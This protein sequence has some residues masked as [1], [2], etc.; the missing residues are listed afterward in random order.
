MLTCDEDTKF[1]L[2]MNVDMDEDEYSNLLSD[3]AMEQGLSD[4]GG[5]KY[6][7]FGE[8]YYCFRANMREARMHHDLIHG[9]MGRNEFDDYYHKKEGFTVELDGTTD[10]KRITFMWKEL[11]TRPTDIMFFAP[12]RDTLHPFLDLF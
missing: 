3:S 9:S 2:C 10:D 4:I 6:K 7:I 8:V 5:D 11:V 1:L 12:P